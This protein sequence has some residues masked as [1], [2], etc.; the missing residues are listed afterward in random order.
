MNL[1]KDAVKLIRKSRRE[2]MEEARAIKR[3]ELL[4]KRPKKLV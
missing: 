1:R 4:K 3:A 2:R